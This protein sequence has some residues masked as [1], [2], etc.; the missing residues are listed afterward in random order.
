M[1]RKAILCLAMTAS[2]SLVGCGDG[3]DGSP[4]EPGQPGDPT[5]PVATY[6]N[7]IQINTES[8]DYSEGSIALIFNAENEQGLAISGLSKIRLYATKNGPEGLYGVDKEKGI[9]EYPTT[10]G[11][12]LEELEAGRYRLTVPISSVT[13]TDDSQLVLLTLSHTTDAGVAIPKQ[14][15][16][17]KYSDKTYSVSTEKCAT[18]HVSLEELKMGWHSPVNDIANCNTCHGDHYPDG[19]H[20]KSETP[21]HKLGHTIHR[22]NFDVGFDTLNCSSCHANEVVTTSRGCNDCHD[23]QQQSKIG[24]QIAYSASASDTDW[25]LVHTRVQQRRQLI[26][27]HD[28]DIIVTPFDTSTRQYCTEVTIA[29]LAPSLEQQVVD[30][31]IK[32]QVYFVDSDPNTKQVLNSFGG[33]G[34]TEAPTYSGNTMSLCTKPVVEEARYPLVSARFT[35]LDPLGDGKNVLLSKFSEAPRNTMSVE[36]CSGCHNSD[37]TAQA[38]FVRTRKGGVDKDHST[39]GDYNDGGSSCL[40][41][42]N[43]GAHYGENG[44]LMGAI[45]SYHFGINADARNERERSELGNPKHRGS[46]EKLTPSQCVV[47][48]QKGI[49]LNAVEPTY[50]AMKEHTNSDGVVSGGGKNSPISEACRSCHSDEKAK[51]HMQSQGGEFNVIGTDSGFESCAVCHATGSSVGIEKFHKISL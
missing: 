5:I 31:T 33:Y 51:M 12:A 13:E 20:F 29:N 45:H 25:R 26:E 1:M 40:A 11:S 39:F 14:Y 2:L 23:N 16:M 7:R 50:L 41:C 36:S 21:L 22:D 6:V 17:G 48:H 42:H 44:S 35:L 3:K 15:A 46:T 49:D 24:K 8:V 19:G 18:C 32:Q 27:N 43:A 34:G 28:I 30:G 10:E 38:I 9:A 37:H 4:G 47:C